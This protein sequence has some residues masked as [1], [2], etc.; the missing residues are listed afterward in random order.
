METAVASAVRDV[1]QDY[2]FALINRLL[3]RLRATGLK[4]PLISN[5]LQQ[6]LCQK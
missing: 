4:W 1:L 2:P 5:G 3:Y 6:R